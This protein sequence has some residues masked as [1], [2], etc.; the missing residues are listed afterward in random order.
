[1]ALLVFRS[2]A[3]LIKNGII[4]FLNPRFQKRKGGGGLVSRN[5][6]KFEERVAMGGITTNVRRRSDYSGR[7]S[8]Y[9]CLLWKAKSRIQRDRNGILPCELPLQRGDWSVS[10]RDWEYELLGLKRGGALQ[11]SLPCVCGLHQE[12]GG[13]IDV[14]CK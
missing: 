11:C 7:A 12:T 6:C 5:L 9:V 2:S 8:R 13:K 4:R 3:I 1:M 10:D 14:R